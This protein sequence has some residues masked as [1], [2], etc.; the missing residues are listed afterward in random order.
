MTGSMDLVGRLRAAIEQSK[1]DNGDYLYLGAPDPLLVDL[2]AAHEHQA[3]TIARLEALLVEADWIIE[4]GVSV[5]IS[6]EELRT[7]HRED[8]SF[9][10]RTR[11]FLAAVRAALHKED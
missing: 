7:A 5:R 3:E 1:S 10:K 11:R 2:L 4:A 9:I 8:R 6:D